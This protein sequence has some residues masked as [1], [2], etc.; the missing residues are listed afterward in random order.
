MNDSNIRNGR[1]FALLNYETARDA[2]PRIRIV[3]QLQPRI[4]PVSTLYRWT[5]ALAVLIYGEV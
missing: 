4:W 1:P 3:A 5:F 2:R